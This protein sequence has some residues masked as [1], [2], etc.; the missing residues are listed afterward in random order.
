M[1][2]MIPPDTLA[3]L[4]AALCSDFVLDTLSLH[5]VL[6]QVLLASLPLSRGMG[7]CCG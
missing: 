2:E 3:R 6:P 4:F 1:K 5:A 7:K